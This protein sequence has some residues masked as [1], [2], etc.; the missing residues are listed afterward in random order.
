[1]GKLAQ[2]TSK[3]TVYAHFQ[4][5]GTVEKPDI[6]G[7]V[8]GQT[9]G[10]LG[11]D[12]DLRELQKT[13]RV[14]R[15][16]VNAKI[17]NG[18]TSGYIIIPSSLDA[19]ETALIAACVETIERVGP[20]SAKI[21][22]EKIEDVRA[23]K[24]KYVVE[25]AKELL[26]AMYDQGSMELG[27]ITEQIKESVRKAEV[28]KYKG[29]SAGPGVRNSDEIIIVEGRADVINLLRCGIKN[30]IA[31]EGTSVPPAIA[32]LTRSK[33]VT[34][35]LDGDRGG[36]LNLKE[37][38]ATSEIDFVARAPDGK[39]VEEL[40]K[41]EIFKAI[42]EKQPIGTL[43]ENTNKPN[44]KPIKDTRTKSTTDRRPINNKRPE[45][46]DTNNKP[47]RDTRT[48]SAAPRKLNVDPRRLEIYKEMLESLTGTRAALFLD[49]LGGVIGKVPVPE[50]FNA[51]K[52]IDADSLIIDG[53]IDQKLANFCA[54]RGVK[55][56]IGSKFSGRIQFPDSLTLLTQE[57]L[58]K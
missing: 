22:I 35:F 5:D 29:L 37:L 9:E 27:E 8:F 7:A 36:D 17:I 48:R 23:S 15:I 53:E 21:M 54:Q 32:E 57:N 50:M 46:R 11:Q 55:Y 39:E 28:I 10:L 40:S 34:V 45:R 1:M 13:G 24:R 49:E 38:Q 42:R 2:A 51:L 43:S 41:K 56:L 33:E 47:V 52:Q 14:G 26:E 30:S 19:S 44:R 20:C 6:I 18:K 3:Y 58:N 12:M 31:M 16:D 25:R 4:A